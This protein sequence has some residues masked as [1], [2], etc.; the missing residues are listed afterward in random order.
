MEAPKL[1]ITEQDGET[2]MFG[3]CSVCLAILPTIKENG[4]D[5]NI[6]LLER[7]FQVHVNAEHSDQPR[8]WE[9]KQ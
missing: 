1:I 6:R 5:R 2:L 3:M 8:K 9:S 7:V 4:R